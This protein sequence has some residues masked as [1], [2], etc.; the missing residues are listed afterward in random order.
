MG[1]QAY[2][3]PLDFDA[4]LDMIWPGYL[5]NEC[6]LAFDPGD[7]DH[8]DAGGCEGCRK[9]EPP[10]GPGWQLWETTTEGSPQSPV[11]A[12]LDE[13][14]AWC[15]TNAT[16]FGRSTASKEQW[17]QMLDENFVH[18]TEHYPGVTATFI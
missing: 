4:P 2:R 7:D 8:I 9:I 12:T 11:F 16:T 1:R 15:E 5:R 18:H 10:A 17:R 14:A 3:V 6:G 13:L